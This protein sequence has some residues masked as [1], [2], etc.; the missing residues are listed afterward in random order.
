MG[1]RRPVGHQCIRQAE[2]FQ[3]ARYTGGFRPPIIL[4]RLANEAG[5]RRVGS[6][7]QYDAFVIASVPVRVTRQSVAKINGHGPH[8]RPRRLQEPAREDIVG[9]AKVHHGL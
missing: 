9:R 4:Q 2:R 6:K 8:V 5:T 3:E 1:Q 7:V